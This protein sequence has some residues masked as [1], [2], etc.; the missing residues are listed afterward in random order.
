MKIGFDISQTGRLKAGCGYFADGLIRQLAETDRK[1]RYLLYPAVG[2]LFWDP[3]CAKSTFFT[4]RPN[5]ERAKAPASFERSRAFWR[6]PPADFEHQLGSPDVFHAN[7]FFCP[8]LKTARLVYTLYDLGYLEEPAWTTEANRAGCF[9]GTFNASLRA[10]R[11]VAISEYSRSHFLRVFPHYPEDRIGVVYPGSRFET[12]SSLPRPARLGQLK[13]DNFWLSVAT[14]EPRK[15]HR[16]LIEAYSRVRA[17]TGSALPLV[18]AGGRGWLMEDFEKTLAGLKAGTDVILTG[19]VNDSELQ[20]LYENCFAFVYPSLFEGFGLPVLEAMSLG[21][22]VISSNTSSLPEIVGSAGVLVNPCDVEEIA[23][24]MRRLTAGDGC[25]EAL[26][27]LAPSRARLFS[28]R[29]AARQVLEL[30]QEL[31]RPAGAAAG[32]ADRSPQSGQLKT[33]GYCKE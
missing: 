23:A 9:Q 5:F 27:A 20:W 15:N 3:D 10:D 13:P 16:R 14:L 25:R 19:Y 29:S 31:A 18:L 22:A 2:D 1:N 12:R 8:K 33:A 11:I 24:A 7:N 4:D 28:W 6:N 17:E 30:Y 32:P 21:A 26:R